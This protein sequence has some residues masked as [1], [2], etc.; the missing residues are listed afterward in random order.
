[1]FLA[2]SPTHKSYK[3]VKQ[4]SS[5]DT[6][7]PETRAMGIESYPTLFPVGCGPLA[8]VA[9]Q[10][11][12]P[13]EADRVGKTQDCHRVNLGLPGRSMRSRPE[14]HPR[15]E[16]IR[17]CSRDARS[18]Q[19]IPPCCW[20]ESARVLW[21]EGLDEVAVKKVVVVVVEEEEEEEEQDGVQMARTC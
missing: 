19:Q 11:S 16:V 4:Q 6:R 20:D 13:S 21:E 7:Q 2:I 12:V 1:M 15:P 8:K 9:L 17:H 3:L 10:Q 5:T 14:I 18:T